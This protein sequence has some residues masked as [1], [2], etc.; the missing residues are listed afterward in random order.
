MAT[1]IFVNI[2]TSDLD[3]SKAFFEGIGWRIEPN[4]T[5]ENAAC[6]RI[7]DAIYLMVLTRDFFATFTDKPIVD[8]ATAVQAEIALSMDSRE[9][10]DEMIATAVAAGGTAHRGPQEMGFMYGRDFE[11]PD[12]N[13]FSVF[14]M[15]P[16]AAEQ[17]PQQTEPS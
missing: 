15:D 1:N 10:V 12:G 8:P 13:L 7:D 2:P 14:W 6:V 17:G 5:D 11:D 9:A 16:V 4:F 3:R